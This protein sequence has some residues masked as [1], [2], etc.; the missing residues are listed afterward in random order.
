MPTWPTSLPQK[1]LQQGY[2]EN[3]PN[4]LIRTQ[5]DKGP[6]KVRR[7]FTAGVR[8]FGTQFLLS[9]T[10][11]ST[12]ETF[13]DDELEGGALRFD[14]THPRTGASVSFRIVPQGEDALLS[15]SAVSDNLYRVQMQLEILP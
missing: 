4:T 9:D 13:I 15:Y 7:R 8:T 14:W 1:P 12:L 3:K 2:D 5:M 10:Q 6:D 11:V